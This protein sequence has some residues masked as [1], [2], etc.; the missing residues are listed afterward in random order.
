MVDI[1]ENTAHQEKIPSHTPESTRISFIGVIEKT[2][3]YFLCS[4]PPNAVNKLGVKFGK[5]QCRIKDR[6]FRV[7][8]FQG[9]R[10]EF[11]D[12]PGKTFFILRP[13]TVHELK[14]KFGKIRVE[15]LKNS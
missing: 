13:R 11:S 7:E 12:L 6:E 3:K 1:V 5:F 15:L 2:R 9:G 8:I 4:L 14:L 10:G